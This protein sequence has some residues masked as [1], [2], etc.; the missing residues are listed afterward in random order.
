M[1]VR[2]DAKSLVIGLLVGCALILVL[3][4]AS[5]REEGRYQL[6]MSANDDYVVY[7]RIDTAT[8]QIETWKYAISNGPVRH[9]GKDTDILRGKDVEQ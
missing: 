2:I 4:A 3:G 9:L 1:T 7:G 8:G 6:S 5:D